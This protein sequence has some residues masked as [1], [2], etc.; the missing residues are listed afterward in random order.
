MSRRV[1]I[2]G[3]GAVTPIG[4]NV[5]TFWNN[6]KKGIC[7]ISFIESFD[8][9]DSKVK[10]AAEIKDFSF[11]HCIDKKEAKRMGRFTQ[12]AICAADEAVKDSG[13]DLENI[14]S[15][16]FGVSVGSGIGGLE[17]M[18]KEY[19]SMLKRGI[20]KVSPLTIPI[21]IGNMAAGNI[22]IKY[23]AKGPCTCT[24]TACATGT[25][26][27]GE[28]FR[29]IKNGYVDIMLAG[30]SEASI[31][32]L[33]VSGFTALTALTKSEDPLRASIPFDKERSGFVMGE[34]AG[35]VVLEEMEHAINR[36][37]NILAEVVG[38]GLTCDAH[39]ITAPAPDGEGGARAIKIA[40]NEAGI[41]KEEVG[42]VNAHGTS[43]ELNDKF[44]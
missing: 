13:L 11:E 23:G 10:V 24:V 2:T 12:F 21:M 44:E 43:T 4:Q 1:V 17:T 28:A 36:G 32:P 31:T 29:N 40:L 20:G 25:D 6:A 15:E 33:G 30:G 41:Q 18:E 22:A 37:A 27:I 38:Y 39:H 19:Q 35:M 34:G 3:I 14:N 42:Y 5:D 7:G 16:R 9:T 8:I 26:C